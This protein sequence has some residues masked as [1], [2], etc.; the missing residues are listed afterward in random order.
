VVVAPILYV[1]VWLRRISP[2]ART[3]VVPTIAALALAVVGTLAFFA[4]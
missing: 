2:G 3:P 1:V 4:K